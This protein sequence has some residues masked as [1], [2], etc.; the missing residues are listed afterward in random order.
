MPLVCCEQAGTPAYAPA[1]V[2]GSGCREAAADTLAGNRRSDASLS[3][4]DPGIGAGA[5][6]AVV[7]RAQAPG[8]SR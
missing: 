3:A 2:W 7:M 1:P 8:G 5:R 4:P 6:A